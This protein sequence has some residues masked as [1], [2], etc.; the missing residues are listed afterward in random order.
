MSRIR[1]ITY[2]ITSFEITFM[3]AASGKKIMIIEDEEMLL[4]AI[5]RKLNSSGFQTVTCTNA[6]QAVDYLNNFG[7]LPD[8]IWLDYYLP[9]M[10]GVDFMEKI[11]E[12]EKW[13]KIPVIVVSNSASEKKKKAMYELG[14]KKYVLKAK[15]KLD[16]IVK[17]VKEIIETNEAQTK[18]KSD[19]N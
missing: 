7:E 13:A 8:I 6:S 10:N 12:N 18:Q 11:R 14:V 15:Y 4:N 16:E 2:D 3:N 17:I 5:S 19:V 1:L 9:D